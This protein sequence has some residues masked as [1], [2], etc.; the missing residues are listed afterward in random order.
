MRFI[1][2]WALVLTVLLPAEG[3]AQ[4]NAPVDAPFVLEHSYWIE[5]GQ[6]ERFLTLFNKNKLPLLKREI[7]DGRIL[8]MRITRPRLR[9]NATSQPDLRLTI[10]WRNSVV[11][12]DDV[13]PSRFVA[14]LFRNQHAWRAEEA[15]RERL[16]VTRADVP[17]QEQSITTP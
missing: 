1:A 2:V 12:W 6:T 8:W 16:V 9:S 17:V 10:A 15:E 4:R 3:T 5:P 7:A 11:A 13:D 14:A